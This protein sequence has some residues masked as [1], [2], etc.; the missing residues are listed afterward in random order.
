MVKKVLSDLNDEASKNK[1]SRKKSTKKSASSGFQLSDEF[2]Y[3]P[4]FSATITQAGLEKLKNNPNVEKVYK[5]AMMELPIFSN[6]PLIKADQ[7]WDMQINGVNINGAGQTVCLLDT[8]VDYTQPELGGCFGDGCKIAGGYDFVRDD[9]EP[10][11]EVKHGTVS[12]SIIISNITYDPSKHQAWRLI[13]VAPS[14]RILAVK[15]CLANCLTSK[16]IKG[17]EWCLDN[18]EKYGVS[19]ILP[20][21]GSSQLFSETCDFNM[22]TKLADIAA[23]YGIVFVAPSGNHGNGSGIAEP[24]CARGAISVGGTMGTDYVATDYDRSQADCAMVGNL[25]DKIWCFSNRGPNLDLVAAATT[26]TDFKG[27]VGTSCAAPYVAGVA[28]LMQQYAQLKY[29]TRL[30]PQQIE[31]IMKATGKPIYDDVMTNVK[32]DS[33]DPLKIISY[34]PPTYLTFPR[35]DALAAI[36]GIDELPIG[37][38][39]KPPVIDSLTPPEGDVAILQGDT[40][41]FTVDAHDPDGDSLSYKWRTGRHGIYD[42]PYDIDNLN[43]YDASVDF[44]INYTLNVTVTDGYH[45]KILKE[46]NVLVYNI[47]FID[48]WMSNGK[49]F[50]P[51]LK[52]KSG[53][54]ATVYPADVWYYNIPDKSFSWSVNGIEN[55]NSEVG[56]IVRNGDESALYTA[57]VVTEEKKFTIKISSVFDPNVNKSLDVTVLPKTSA[58]KMHVSSI[59]MSRLASKKLKYS[60]AVVTIVNDKNKPVK[61]ALVSGAWSGAVNKKVSGRTDSSG[62]AAFASRKI[63]GVKGKKFTFCVDGASK[64]NFDYEPSANSETC[65]S[66]NTIKVLSEASSDELYEASDASDES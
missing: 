51:P 48:P 8:G 43:Y 23:D 12:A 9:N 44:S 55:G 54:S 5:S 42:D 46:W 14:A 61:N 10:D 20:V 37:I 45:E 35:I 66:I 13:G 2:S 3:V 26:S 30:H 29:G 24:A 15:V 60:K 16:I 32:F 19:V 17:L 63:K 39:N 50:I 41:R 58:N 34:D 31:D 27:C 7:V 59:K 18:K 21:L 4:G 1:K 6:V 52:M 47:K 38:S 62:K 65:D 56:T 33:V 53:E 25:T 64:K 11:D 36:K 57:P 28:A 40:Y 22:E 49:H